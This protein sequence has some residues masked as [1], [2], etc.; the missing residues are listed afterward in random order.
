[1]G[2]HC[3]SAAVAAAAVPVGRAQCRCNGDGA[4]GKC[5]SS[6]G[7]IVVTIVVS[8]W[9]KAQLAKQDGAEQGLHLRYGGHIGRA[10][11]VQV[12]LDRAEWRGG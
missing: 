10:S 6:R 9:E 11:G 1:M 5:A 3:V 12:C 8:Y 7:Y 2:F 4:G